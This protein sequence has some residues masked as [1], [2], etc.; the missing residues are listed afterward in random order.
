MTAR[1]SRRLRAWLKTSRRSQRSL[2][3]ELGVSPA[4]IA[5]ILAS[6]RTPSL[7]IA[8]RLQDV[9]GIPAPEFIAQ[10]LT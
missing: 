7:P 3:Q 5:M 4:Y 10:N 6:K 9:T 8:K 2:A 1:S